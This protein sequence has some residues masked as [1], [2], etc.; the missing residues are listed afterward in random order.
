MFRVGQR[1]SSMEDGRTRCLEQL[2]GA[3]PCQAGGKKKH[4]KEQV[5]LL[6][7]CT[8]GLGPCPVGCVHL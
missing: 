6:E 3:G 1:A 8:E 7:S 5:G 4:R 2:V